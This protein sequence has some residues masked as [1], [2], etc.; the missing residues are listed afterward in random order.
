MNRSLQVTVTAFLSSHP[1]R[2]AAIKT[3]ILSY[4]QLYRKRHIFFY[5]KTYKIYFRKMQYDCD[6]L[7]HTRRGLEVALQVS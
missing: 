3:L 4:E 1:P 5:I 6:G 7:H 2:L